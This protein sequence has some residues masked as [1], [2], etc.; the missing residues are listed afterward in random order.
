MGRGGN[1]SIEASPPPVDIEKRRGTD[2]T[3]LQL[4]TPLHVLATYQGD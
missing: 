1:G 3:Q 2:E 4:S